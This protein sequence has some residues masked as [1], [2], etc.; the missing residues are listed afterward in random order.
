MDR[1][2]EELLTSIQQ[3]PSPI[4]YFDWDV[5][6]GFMLWSVDAIS[7]WPMSRG[8]KFIVDKLIGYQK[9][10]AM[11]VSV[12]DSKDINEFLDWIEAASESCA[13]NAYVEGIVEIFKAY[14]ER[15]QEHQNRVKSLTASYWL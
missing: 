12:D 14:R 8:A 5:L 11:S 2:R 4:T 10:Y 9:H 6:N 13:M 3:R 15:V 7:Y 1:R